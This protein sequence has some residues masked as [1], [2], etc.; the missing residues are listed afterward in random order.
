MDWSAS[1]ANNTASI[2]DA[3]RAFQL[4]LAASPGGG[5]YDNLNPW[6]FLDQY[7][8]GDCITLANVA[9]TGLNMLGIPA[10]ATYA[11]PTADG[12]S[13]F[14]AVSTA[15]CTTQTTATFTY[16]GQSFKAKLVYVGDNN[17]EG[18][19]TIVDAG[20]TKAYTVYPAFDPF[21][22][23]NYYYLDIIR[24]SSATISGSIQYWV[25]VPGQPPQ[26]GVSVT[27][28]EP[29]VNAAGVPLPNVPVPNDPSG[30]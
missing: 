4:G 5:G 12:S 29:V 14:P 30:P 26:N 8:S 6:Q 1:E 10:S 2:S 3:A 24:T 11:W 27:G 9:A 19:F 28:G 13:G 17:F 7:S 21:T 18:F 20:Q 15:T 16:E 22:N 23:Q 25:W